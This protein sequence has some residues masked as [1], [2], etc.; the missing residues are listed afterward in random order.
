VLCS[1][2]DDG[3]SFDAAI[4]G[5]QSAFMLDSQRKQVEIREVFGSRHLMV[6]KL[7]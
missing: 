3:L 1:R 5:H 7:G 4:K 6:I 2:S